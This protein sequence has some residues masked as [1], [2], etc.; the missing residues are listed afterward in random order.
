MLKAVNIGGKLFLTFP[1]ESSV[2]YPKREETLNYYDDMTH[3]FYPP[4]FEETLKTIRDEG[5]ELIHAIKNYQPK[6]LFYFGLFCEPISKIRKKNMIGTWEYYNFE[7]I[8][9]D[10]KK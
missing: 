4:N 2:N 10:K 6:I 8:I 5:F 7:S 9:I 3:K 1:C